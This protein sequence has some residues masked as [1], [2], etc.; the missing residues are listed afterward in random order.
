MTTRKNRFLVAAAVAAL[1]AGAGLANAQG[2]PESNPAAKQSPAAKSAPAEKMA[3][4]PRA[5]A[6]NPSASEPKGAQRT[7]EKAPANRVGETRENAPAG[8]TGESTEKA[9][10]N[11]MGET[12]KDTPAKTGQAAPATRS[13]S[14]TTGQAPSQSA[15]KATDKDDKLDKSGTTTRPNRAGEANERNERNER[16][17]TQSRG[18]ATSGSERSETQNRGGAT[19]GSASVNLSPEQKTRIHQVII[20]DR[21]APRVASANFQL[22]VGVR[23][24]HDVRLAPLPPTLVEIEPRWRGFEYFL[25]GDEIVIVD[26]H[27]LEIVAVIEA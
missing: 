19:S 12:K 15:P 25:V 24:P 17:E 14:E 21:A 22:N 6:M 4:A 10:A 11:R 20:G 9:P 27:T 2:V 5:P 26:P 16:S 3:P 18:G 7:D 13:K 8:R 23:V 1:T